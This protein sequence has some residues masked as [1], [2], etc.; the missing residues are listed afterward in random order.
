[1]RDW[2]LF[3]GSLLAVPQ[4]DGEA[5]EIELLS[6][7]MNNRDE[8]KVCGERVT[9]KTREQGESEGYLLQHIVPCV[10]DSHRSTRR[11]LP[12]LEFSDLDF[13]DFHFS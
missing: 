10:L 6:V 8:V 13:A 2:C 9:G 11:T 3:V 12:D 1:M 5:D 4:S 7:L